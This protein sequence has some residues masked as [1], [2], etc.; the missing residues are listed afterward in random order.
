MIS[1]HRKT[2]DGIAGAFVHNSHQGVGYRTHLQPSNERSSPSPGAGRN[3]RLSPDEEQRLLNAVDEH[4]NPMLGWIV[5]D[6]GMR[7][8]GITSLTL[9]QVNLQKRIV[10]LQE[11]KNTMPRTFPLTLV[12]VEQFQQAIDNPVRPPDTNLVFFGEPGR[13]GIRKPYTFNKVWMYIKKSIGLADLRFHDL[14]HEAVS[15][16]FEVC[17]CW[18]G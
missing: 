5:I 15:R 6:T 9:G 16:C 14:R 11:T 18:R 12:S 3:R 17:C 4:S 8:S 13:D 7:S 2:R 1:Q 10:T